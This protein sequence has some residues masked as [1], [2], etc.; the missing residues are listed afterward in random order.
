[1]TGR[2]PLWEIHA[3]VVAQNAAVGRIEGKLEGID[4]QLAQREAEHDQLEQRTRTLEGH[5][6]SREGVTRMISVIAGLVSGAIAGF[7]GRHFT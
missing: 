3:L 2:D 7:F 5:Q 1:M 4:R 6:K